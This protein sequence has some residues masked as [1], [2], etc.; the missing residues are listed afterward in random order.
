MPR[1]MPLIRSAALRPFFT[2]AGVERA[3]PMP[4]LQEAGLDWVPP[5]EPFWPVPLL[6]AIRLYAGILRHRG[7]ACIDEI[8]TPRVTLDL[9]AIGQVALGAGTPVEA[10]ARVAVAMPYHCSHEFFTVTGTADTV[11]VTDTHAV[12]MSQEECHVVHL[13]DAAVVR[14]VLLLTGARDPVF[15]S[16]L[17]RPHPAFGLSALPGWLAPVA[18]ATDG[19]SLRITLPR[20]LAE[21]PFR[22]L[23]RNRSGRAL[24]GL[25]SLRDVPGMAASLRQF[26]PMQLV[27]RTPGLAEMAADAG[28]SVRSFQR[29]LSADGTSLTSLIDGLRREQA[30]GQIAGDRQA[31]TRVALDIGFAHGSSLSR[32]VRRWT[33]QTPTTLRLP[34]RGAAG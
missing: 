23:G 5:D 11:V 3:D 18:E 28:M 14:Q 6:A 29:Q 33:G 8:V 13:F 32:A 19:R 20:S 2:W 25:T 1:T 31:L 21:R 27:T 17:M 24:A 12:P 4:M 22:S 10:L 16:V 15:R 9:A 26:L 34:D 7:P 30:L